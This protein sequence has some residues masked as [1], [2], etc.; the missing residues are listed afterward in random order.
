MIT[1]A[2]SPQVQESTSEVSLTINHSKAL[3]K[4]FLSKMLSEQKYPLIN[5]S[6]V[7]TCSLLGQTLCLPHCLCW[8]C[9]WLSRHTLVIYLLPVVLSR[10]GLKPHWS[11]YYIF[12]PSFLVKCCLY[13]FLQNVIVVSAQGVKKFFIFSVTCVGNDSVDIH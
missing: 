8:V 7:F 11:S 5:A 4:Y 13:F 10:P 12:S 3:G 1:Q 2:I 6:I 9:K